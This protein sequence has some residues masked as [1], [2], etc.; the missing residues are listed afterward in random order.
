[1]LFVRVVAVCPTKESLSKELRATYA[2]KTFSPFLNHL[3]DSTG[4]LDDKFELGK[5]VEAAEAKAA[6]K[7]ENAKRRAEA[8]KYQGSKV[9]PMKRGVQK[10]ANERILTRAQCHYSTTQTR[11]IRW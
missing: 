10:K 7:I 11:V 9:A 4:L 1:M 3:G 6:K 5:R 8:K 2:K